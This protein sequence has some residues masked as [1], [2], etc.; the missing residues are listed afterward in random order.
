MNPLQIAAYTLVGSL[1]LGAIAGPRVGRAE[2]PATQAVAAGPASNPAVNTTQVL[3]LPFAPTD[4]ADQRAWIGKAFEQSVIAELSRGASVQ[5]MSISQAAPS[6]GYDAATALAAARGAGE[7][8][9]GERSMG[10]KFVIFGSFQ[11]VGTDVRV[12][13]QILDVETGRAVGGLRATGALANLFDVEDALASQ[14]RRQLPGATEEPSATAQ[15]DARPSSYLEPLR[16]A[17]PMRSIA[18]MPDNALPDQNALLNG[19]PGY[20]LGYGGYGDY[21]DYANYAYEG[22]GPVYGYGGGFFPF[23][24]GA[25]GGYIRHGHGRSPVSPPPPRRPGAGGSGGRR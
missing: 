10:A 25:G 22:Y 2:A 13:G 18:P 5:P 20:D 6:A 4:P 9:T 8:G 17:P 15:A 24:Y 11:T 7:R 14:V 23:I 1:A 12:L 19:P 3:V 21:C 16:A